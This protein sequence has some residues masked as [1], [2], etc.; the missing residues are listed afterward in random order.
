LEGPKEK[1]TKLNDLKPSSK[2]GSPGRPLVSPSLQ[3]SRSQTPSQSGSQLLDRGNDSDGVIW[4]E[5][6]ITSPVNKNDRGRPWQRKPSPDRNR[7]YS[8]SPKRGQNT[9]YIN[10]TSTSPRRSNAQ[11][12]NS[13]PRYQ[14]N[15]RNTQK[16]QAQTS[17]R[18]L[19]PL[20]MS[21][22]QLHQFQ[23]EYMKKKQERRQYPVALIGSER[24]AELIENDQFDSDYDSNQS[25]S[26]SN[27]DFNNPG[28][29]SRRK[30]VKFQ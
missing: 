25:S 21:A 15:K 3:T 17:P 10:S 26:R 11:N 19:K 22:N 7:S 16:P 18:T 28:S 27:I 6:E 12:V 2:V 4:Q 24:K 5:S 9:N 8:P 23:S 20:K 29:L 30:N 13:S 1:A 14:E